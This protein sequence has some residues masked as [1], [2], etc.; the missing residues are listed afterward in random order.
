MINRFEL[1]ALD[2]YSLLFRFF[3][4]SKDRDII[5]FIEK[6]RSLDILMNFFTLDIGYLFIGPFCYFLI[7]H[8]WKYIELL[9][10]LKYEGGKL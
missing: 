4:Y 6:Y 5:E 8:V 7:L 10:Y 1:H 2:I 3:R 9:E